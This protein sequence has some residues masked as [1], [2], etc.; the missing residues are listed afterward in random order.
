MLAPL[1]IAVT[2][3]SNGAEAVEAFEAQSFDIVLMDMQMPVMDGLSATR[4]IRDIEARERRPATPIVMLS[5]NALR[6][7]EDQ[8]RAAGCDLHVAKPVTPD[9]LFVA[10]A[11]AATVRAERN[12][13]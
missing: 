11:A 1:G 12:A 10:L 9:R 13:A 2:V 5:A 3:T 8:S 7:H 6:E 4:A